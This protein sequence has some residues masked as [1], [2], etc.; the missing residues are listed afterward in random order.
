M[1]WQDRPYYRDSDS[2]SRANPLM[3]LL[4][5]SIHLFT[6]FGIRVRAHAALLLLIAL[7][8]LLGWGAGSSIAMRVQ[9][10]TIIFGII[11]LH[12]FGHCFAARWMGGSADEI[13]MT[14]IGGLAFAM[15]PRRPWPT[16]VTVAGGPAVN[17]VICLLCG[18]GLYLSIGV[19]PLGPWSFERAWDGIASDGWIQL[20]GFLFWAYAVSYALLLFNLLPVFPLDGGQLL[21]SILWKPF[22]YYKSMLWTVTIGIAGGALMMLYGIVSFGS[23]WG[24]LLL[25]FIGL[26]C[27]LTCMQ[28]R[29]LL[30]AEGPWAFQEEDSVDYSYAASL[31]PERESRRSKWLARRR[32]K[33]LRKLARAEAMERQTVDHILEKVGKHGMQSLTWSERRTLRKATEHQRQRDAEMS[34]MR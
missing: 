3:W 17:V 21:Q 15:A 8:L 11:L 34:K 19:W 24:G 13:L 22:G 27:M 16:F 26:S 29:R 2:G 12:E 1:A 6:V 31:R 28:Y 7:I 4:T 14:P 33:K 25:I 20:A 32:M 18:A 10:A 23:L 30:L 9:S 5:G